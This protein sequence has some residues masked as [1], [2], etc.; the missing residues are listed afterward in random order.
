MDSH[1]PHKLTDSDRKALLT[2]SRK[3]LVAAFS[4]AREKPLED[5]KVETKHLSPAIHSVVPCFV[6]LLTR[7]KRLRGCIGSLSTSNPL[8][9]NVFEYTQRA[10]FEDPRF[11]P[12]KEMEIPS[13]VIEITALGPT[14]PLPS[15]AQLEIGKHGLV[16]EYHNRRGVLLAQ[17]ATEWGWTKEEFLKQVCEKANLEPSMADKYSFFYFE[18]VAFRE[19]EKASKS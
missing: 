14:L 10:A 13:L 9:Q 4:S 6:T 8:Y 12:L 3:T 1:P 5:F 7:G 11:P 2:L 19:N 15:L 17:V 18:E 16:V